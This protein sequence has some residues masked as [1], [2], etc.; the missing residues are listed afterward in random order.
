MNM[1]SAAPRTD[2]T[3]TRSGIVAGA[4]AGQAMAAGV[5]V[6]GMVFGVLASEAQL[7]ALEAL[8]M[9]GAIYSGTAQMAA[10]QGWAH[11]RLLLP[12]IATILIMNAR[13]VLYGA[14]LR[15]WL[16][17]LPPY[18]S[19]PTLFFLGDGSWALSMQRRAA[20]EVDAGF[21]FGSSFVMFLPWLVGTA[22]GSLVGSAI[23]DPAR[24]GLDFMLVAFSAALAVSVWRGRSDLLP[25]FAALLVALVVNTIS[26]GGWTIVAAGLT[27]ALVAYVTFDGRARA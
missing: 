7:T 23:P 4:I 24:F 8:L 15:P 26:P 17:A 6:Y 10:L 18:L 1:Q 9:S 12:A 19:Y 3:F 25:G 13:Y 2:I 16:G 14:A 20:G 5:L 21:V 22:I 27:G 11:T